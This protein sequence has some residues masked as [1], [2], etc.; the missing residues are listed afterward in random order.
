ML[1][2]A[3]FRGQGKKRLGR[4][5]MPWPEIWIYSKSQKVLHRSMYCHNHKKQMRLKLKIFHIISRKSFQNFRTNYKVTSNSVPIF[6]LVDFKLNVMV[7]HY[8]P[9][10]CHVHSSRVNLRLPPHTRTTAP[11]PQRASCRAGT[12]SSMSTGAECCFGA[13]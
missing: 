5:G 4:L 3:L 9:A 1:V 12:L 10:H 8:F 6:V 7:S 13:E 2:Q 11:Q